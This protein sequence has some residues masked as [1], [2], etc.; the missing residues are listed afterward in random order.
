MWWWIAAKNGNCDRDSALIVFLKF[1][2][3]F[4]QFPYR[5]SQW[6]SWDKRQECKFNTIFFT[7]QFLW[8]FKEDLYLDI[9][10]S[11]AV[12]NCRTTLI[13]FI[14]Y[15]FI[16]ITFVISTHFGLATPYGDLD[17]GQHCAGNEPMLIWDNELDSLGKIS[18][19]KD[20]LHIYIQMNIY[21]FFIFSI[22]WDI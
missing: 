20:R 13:M 4:Y 22:T 6:K 11:N 17:L 9:L 12:I 19:T 16:G 8:T 10:V 1:S 21:N 18:V 15:R 7:Y 5:S 2:P 3:F 14:N